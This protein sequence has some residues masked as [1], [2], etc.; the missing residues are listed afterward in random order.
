[1]RKT[2]F[3]I[4]VWLAFAVRLP[5]AESVTL[6]DGS[7]F[8][9]EIVKSDDNGIMLH[10]DGDVYTN[11]PWSR[12]SQQSLK[13]LGQNPKLAGY[14]EPFIE[15]TES[16]HAP[17]PEIKINPVTR[18]ALPANPSLI[19]GLVKSSVGLVMLI[20]LYLANL[21]AAFEV[22]LVR[23]RPLFQVIGISAVL[24]IIGPGIFVYLPVVLD[25]P[26]EEI[27]PAGDGSPAEKSSAKP[28][29]ETNIEVEAVAAAS[30]PKKAAEQVFARGKFTFNKRFVETKF[31]GFV[32]EPKGDGL[33]YTMM[34]KT[35]AEKFTVERIAQTGMAD[36]ILE[37]K[38]RGQVTVSY[39]DIQEIKLNPI[40]T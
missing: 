17:P 33:K 37:T 16:H 14:V 8:S 2:I 36:A 12:F 35:T 38:E 4:C 22:A 5:A 6:T 24:P 23:N 31:A 29:G 20:L 25:K 32:G 19:G 28:V 1:M 13:D 30:Q 11:L 27:V 40:T 26:A 34:L 10:C 18:L 21:Y 39:A 3:L 15:P 7:A 9:G